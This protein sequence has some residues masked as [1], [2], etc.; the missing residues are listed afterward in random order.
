LTQL[1]RNFFT[2]KQGRAHSVEFHFE[3]FGFQSEFSAFDRL[4]TSLTKCFKCSSENLD[5]DEIDSGELNEWVGEGKWF[6]EIEGLSD[7]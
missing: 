5:V 3:R 7:D 4:I 6:V 1:Q 2:F